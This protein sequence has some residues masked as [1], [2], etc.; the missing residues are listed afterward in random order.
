MVL[1]RSY[2]TDVRIV[3]IFSSSS[4]QEST[5]FFKLLELN[6]VPQGGLHELGTLDKV[7]IF[8]LL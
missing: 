5:Y 1:P 3:L 2:C 8:L 7:I 6:T 4:L